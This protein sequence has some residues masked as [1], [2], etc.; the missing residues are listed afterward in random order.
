MRVCVKVSEWRVLKREEGER[1]EPGE[2]ERE[3]SGE[4][5]TPPL[6]PP[7]S[8]FPIFRNKGQRPEGEG[9]PRKLAW[10][11]PARE[12][13]GKALTDSTKMPLVCSVTV[14]LDH[15]GCIK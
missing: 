15:H 13:I 10:G 8:F 5:S 3:K 4:D 11:T 2:R 7:F 9:T 6:S 1:E 14:V 12:D